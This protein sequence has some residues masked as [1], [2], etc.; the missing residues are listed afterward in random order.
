MHTSLSNRTAVTAVQSW[1]NALDLALR[2][3]SA[4]PVYLSA[5][6]THAGRLRND[7]SCTSS[8]SAS[9]VGQQQACHSH[10]QHSRL[11][12][13]LAASA[14]AALSGFTIASCDSQVRSR[15][16]CCR[17]SNCV[18]AGSQSQLPAI[19]CQA[20]LRPRRSTPWRSQVPN[21]RTL[22]GR[23]RQF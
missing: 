6:Q 23:S 3:C 21:S 14:V 9:Q 2:S 10:G 17:W 18:L 12:T 1:V 19:A 16:R 13:A 5:S 20:I 4:F 22:A 15:E 7:P 11:P 8:A